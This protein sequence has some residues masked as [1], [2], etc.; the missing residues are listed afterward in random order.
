MAPSLRILLDVAVYRLRKLEMANMVGAVAIMLTLRLTPEDLAVRTV[1][2]F[3]LNLLAYLVND[4]CDIERDLAIDREAEKT[5]FLAEHR[6]VAFWVQVA[7]FGTLVGVGVLW[8]AGLVLAAA[9]G[10]GICW[11][12]TARLKETP[13]WD[14]AAMAAWGVGMT[15]VA[16]P[17]DSALGWLLAVQ[18]GLFSSCFESIQVLRDHDEDAASGVRTT[19]V[20]LG[21]RRTLLLARC[22]MVVSAAY[23][24][25]L[26]HRH[27]GWAVLFAVLVP[28]DAAAPSRYWNRIRVVLGLAWVAMLGWIFWKGSAYGWISS[29]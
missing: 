20:A 8:S 1:F 15:L 19:A 17:L 3:L 26:L 22:L 12:Y 16:F 18:L 13:Y 2:A 6:Q 29:L 25:L 21:P 5:R 9:A 27:I 11:L 23:A 10:A 4:Y 14:V 24:L 28:F 7:L